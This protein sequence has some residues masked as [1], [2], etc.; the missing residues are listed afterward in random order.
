MRTWLAARIDSRSWRPSARRA[1]GL[2]ARGK[3]VGKKTGIASWKSRMTGTPMVRSGS[4]AKTRKSGI[5]WTWT[6]A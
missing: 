2:A 1:S 3:R 4:P 6:T 5:V